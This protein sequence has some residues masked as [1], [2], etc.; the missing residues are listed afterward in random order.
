MH[1]AV[2]YI[3]QHIIS[4]LQ[5]QPY[6]YIHSHPMIQV[7]N[8]DMTIILCKPKLKSN[9]SSSVLTVLQFLFYGAVLT[10]GLTIAMHYDISYCIWAATIESWRL[11]RS[12]CRCR[13][14]NAGDLAGLVPSSKQ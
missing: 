11:K 2:E 6:V 14:L 13:P 3:E 10:R 9:L 12:K 5:T 1:E 7:Q 4:Q 8:T